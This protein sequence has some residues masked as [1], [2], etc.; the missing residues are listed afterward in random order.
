MTLAL[1]LLAYLSLFRVLGLPPNPNPHPN[2]NPNPN[3]KPR[4]YYYNTVTEETLREHPLDE[5]YRQLYL[6]HAGRLG[7]GLGLE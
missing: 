6:H 4:L 3:P 5:Y 2:P 1:R 7:L